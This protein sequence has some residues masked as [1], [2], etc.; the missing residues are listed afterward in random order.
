MM[1]KYLMATDFSSA[2]SARGGSFVLKGKGLERLFSK[3]REHRLIQ[4]GCPLEFDRINKILKRAFD[5]IGYIDFWS[6][7]KLYKVQEEGYC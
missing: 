7:V 3:N 5:E 1:E 2:I 4:E 6:E